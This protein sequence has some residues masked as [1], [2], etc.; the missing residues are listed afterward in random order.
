MGRRSTGRTNTPSNREAR[1]H[2]T[3]EA[4]TT[5]PAVGLFRFKQFEPFLPFSRETWR[6]LVCDGKAPASIK[7]GNRCTVWAAAEIHKFLNDPVNYRVEVVTHVDH[8][9]NDEG[10]PR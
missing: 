7:L 9:S 2:P 4:L 3:R 5:L 1:R 6:K 8:H 10:P